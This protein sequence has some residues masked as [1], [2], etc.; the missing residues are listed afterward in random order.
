MPIGVV[1][2]RSA[3]AITKAV[4]LCRR[5]Q[6][7]IV[8]R[9]GGTGLAGQGCNVAVLIDCSK[10][11]NRVISIDAVSRVA[12]VEPGCI[13]DNLR[14][15]AE[16]HGLTFGPDPA[17]HD[18]NTLGGMIGN[19]SCG[20]HSVQA[21]RTSDNVEALDILTYDGVRLELGPTGDAELHKHLA[22]GNP[23]IDRQGNAEQS[24]MIQ[25]IGERRKPGSW[26]TRSRRLTNS[27]PIAVCF[28]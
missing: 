7:P 18:H 20:V 3:A 26:L 6:A 1:I 11:L 27:V 14:S 23:F 19:N 24:Y 25:M 12:E 5:F 21:G 28:A 22:A 15:A 13:L 16:R 4:E 2:P 9:G 17:T 10:Y 8:V